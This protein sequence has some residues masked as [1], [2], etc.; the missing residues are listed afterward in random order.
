MSSVKLKAVLPKDDEANGL[1]GDKWAETFVESNAPVVVIAV[2]QTD[3]VT[4]KR[5]SHS[6]IPKVTIL[7][8]EPVTDAGEASELIERMQALMEARNGIA[9][10][11]MEPASNVT[12]LDFEGPEDAA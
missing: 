8:I 9:S 4:E 6:R 3:E 5:A 12:V 7:R 1:A 10:L 11:D 2:L